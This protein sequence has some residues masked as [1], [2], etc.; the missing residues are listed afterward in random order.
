VNWLALV[1]AA[2]LG[3]LSQYYWAK[4][5]DTYE[6]LEAS[7]EWIDEVIEALEQENE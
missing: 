7:W 3:W 6:E 2:P 1:V 5:Q 4:W